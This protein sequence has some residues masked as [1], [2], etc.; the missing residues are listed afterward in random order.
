VSAKPAS[1]L[2]LFVTIIVVLL[3]TPAFRSVLVP[4]KAVLGFLLSIAA[5][6]GAVVRVFQKG[7]LDDLFQLPAVGPIASFVPVLLIGVLF[8][9]AM[10]YE[11]FLVRRMREHFHHHGDARAAVE[12]G[13]RRSGRVVTS[14]ALIM[15]AVFG[16][17]IFDHDPTVKTIGFALTVGVLIDAFGVRLRPT[18]NRCGQPLVGRP[19]RRSSVVAPPAGRW[20]GRV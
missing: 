11:V 15:A 7:H 13:V 17:F 6:L 4:L 10:D 20:S 1:A 16:G 19:H 2:P 8:G 14:A 18:P 3:L 9:L 5:G 12:H